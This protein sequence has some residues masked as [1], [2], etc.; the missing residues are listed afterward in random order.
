MAYAGAAIKLW[1][2]M[3]E[4]IQL[5]DKATDEW[6]GSSSL[7]EDFKT[8]S[9]LGI[10]GESWHPQIMKRVVIEQ[11][12]DY[13]LVKFI[14]AKDGMPTKFEYIGKDAPGDFVSIDGDT[15]LLIDGVV[16]P[17]YTHFRSGHPVKLFTKENDEDTPEKNRPNWQHSARTARPIPAPYPRVP[18]SRSGLPFESCCLQWWAA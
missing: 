16:N 11:K 4:G 10:P 5:L 17:T 9:F 7:R 14:E 8:E 12:Y 6:K 1:K 18:F 2:T 3:E 13:R 15:R